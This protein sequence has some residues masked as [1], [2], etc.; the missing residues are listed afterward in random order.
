MSGPTFKRLTSGAR[1]YANQLERL[2]ALRGQLTSLQRTRMR[3]LARALVDEITAEQ[4]RRRRSR[5]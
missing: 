1:Q 3:S 4:D 5:S 2:V